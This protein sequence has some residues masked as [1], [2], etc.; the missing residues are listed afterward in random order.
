MAGYDRVCVDREGMNMKL[1]KTKEA[2]EKL[3]YSIDHFRKFIKHQPDFPKPV[4]LTPRARPQW[5]DED[6]EN[7]LKQKAA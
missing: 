4:K 6:I 3:R 1:L 5:R 2:A 7:Y